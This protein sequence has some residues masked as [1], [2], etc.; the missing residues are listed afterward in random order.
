[1]TIH[2][3]NINVS[4]IVLAGIFVIFVMKRWNS[5]VQ[6]YIH[7]YAN[8]IVNDH[9]DAHTLER[10]LSY[11]VICLYVIIA[12]QIANIPLD[13][14]AF[15]GG[16]LAIGVGF[17]AQHILNNFIASLTVMIERPMKIGDF[18]EI[19]GV[20]GTVSAIGARCFVIT[21]QSKV[22]IFVP[23]GKLLQRNLSNWT[24]NS[25]IIAHTASVKFSK[26]YKKNNK[27]PDDIFD[28]DDIMKVIRTISD[29]LSGISEI[30]LSKVLFV[31]LSSR[32]YEYT[33]SF[34]YDTTQNS[35]NTIK[36]LINLQIV[37][38]FEAHH[39]IIEYD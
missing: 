5:Y 11:A 29:R 12:L 16:A 6:K 27:N 4:N 25:N 38:C 24:Y 7:V 18:V 10:I 13:A 1:M 37:S 21:T 31:G 9:A 36:H 33:V 39:T 19:D 35:I 28:I 3:H 17:G 30:N 26:F 15:I 8:R 2:S 14:F 22:D 32:Y 34:T 20:S 23:S